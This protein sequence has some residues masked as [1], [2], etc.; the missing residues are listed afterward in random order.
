MEETKQ[1]GDIN[2]QGVTQILS[3]E[4]MWNFI[5]KRLD[6][7]AVKLLHK[8][9][10]RYKVKPFVGQFFINGLTTEKLK[11]LAIPKDPNSE[12]TA[13]HYPSVSYIVNEIPTGD[14]AVIY[15]N[16]VNDEVFGDNFGPSCKYVGYMNWNQKEKTLTA[17][18][19]EVC[20]EAGLLVE[21]IAWNDPCKIEDYEELK[22][23]AIH[24][25]IAIPIQKAYEIVGPNCNNA[26]TEHLLKYMLTEFVKDE[27]EYLKN[28]IERM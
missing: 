20:S 15:C 7:T 11:E 17:D 12:N 10:K 23:F 6:E 5:G 2:M 22:S 14:Y 28:E 21:K 4:E 19:R 25:L 24:I 26:M 27:A 8:A 1:L 13:D 16:D 3:E 18:I 9:C